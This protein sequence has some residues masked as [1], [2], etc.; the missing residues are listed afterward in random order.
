MDPALWLLHWLRLRAWFRR[1]FRNA[2]TLRGALFLAAGVLFFGL[3]V[4]PN[5]GLR[6]LQ[7]EHS[8]GSTASIEHTRRVGPLLLLTYC[9]LTMLFTSAEQG[10]TFTPAEVQFLFSGPF[11][12][13]QVLAYK[14]AGN[15]LLCCLYALF[16]TAFFFGYTAQPL[17]AYPGLVL[18]L[19][20]IQ[21]FSLA[22]SLL[23]NTIGARAVTW[24]RR[25]LVLAGLGLAVWGVARL[26]GDALAHG[27]GE[28]VT[29]LVQNEAV[30]WLLTP[31]RWFIE[32]FTAERLW[33]E[34]ALGALRVPAWMRLSFS[35]SFCLTRSTKK[36]RQ[37]PANGPMPGC[38]ASA[39]AGRW[40]RLSAPAG[41]ASACRRC[42][43]GAAWDRSPGASSPPGR[44]AFAR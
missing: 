39:A 17:A 9:V 38:S 31:M 4:G 23:L 7:A 32:T 8:P 36:R 33:P 12:R 29:R 16:L 2:G 10:I 6:L 15:S 11:S 34:F 14:I 40:R 1:M 43:P 19:W 42:R 24:P 21:F 30:Q 28:V 44:V 35:S 41:L 27:P 22:V 20:F 37:Q 25:V 5:I 13:R 18:T 3:V 26:G